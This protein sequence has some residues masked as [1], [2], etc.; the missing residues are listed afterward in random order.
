MRYQGK[1]YRTLWLENEKLYIIDQNELPENFIIKELENIDAVYKAIVTMQIRGA[2]AIGAIAALGYA[3]ALKKSSDDK[4]QANISGIYN[5]LLSARPTA[6]DLRNGL[7]HVR[8]AIQQEIV[9]EKIKAAALR[10]AQEFV[11]ASVSECLSL[12]RHGNELI[13]DGCRILTH[14]NAGA[15]ATVDHGT[16]LAPIRAA[17]FDGKDIFVYVSETRP[18]LQGAR[19][20][21]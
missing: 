1:N 11:E 14:C 2:P 18:R 13:H 20:T 8:I 21:A 12:G 6:V 3:L 9:A 17:H 4:L 7:D 16:A 15:L 5:L 10:S 19:L